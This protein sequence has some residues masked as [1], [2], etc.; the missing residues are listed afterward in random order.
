MFIY[1]CY[2]LCAEYL[3]FSKTQHHIRLRPNILQN[4]LIFGFGSLPKIIRCTPNICKLIKLNNLFFYYW[5]QLL[6]LV[7]FQTSLWNLIFSENGRDRK[8]CLWISQCYHTIQTYDFLLQSGEVI[9]CCNQKKR[10]ARD[11]LNECSMLWHIFWASYILFLI[12]N[13]L[14]YLSVIILIFTQYCWTYVYLYLN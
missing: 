2:F 10:F 6:F 1:F 14:L 8:N 7:Q 11:V 12:R 13:S 3:K 5:I 4:C 9:S